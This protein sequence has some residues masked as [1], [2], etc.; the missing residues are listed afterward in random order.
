MVKSYA[1]TEK[2][3]QMR[4]ERDHRIETCV[5]G[6]KGLH[7]AKSRHKSQKQHIKFLELAQFQQQQ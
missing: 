5:C 2:A 3:K 1:K 7:A 4:Y 6:W